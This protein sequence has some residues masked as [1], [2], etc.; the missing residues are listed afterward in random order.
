MID[1]A[2][3]AFSAP[4]AYLPELARQERRQ[5]LKLLRLIAIGL[6][7]FELFG[8]QNSPLLSI[9]GALL[10]TAAALLP[11]Y[12]WCSG[13]ALGL[14]IFPLS[15]LPFVWTHAL[16]LISQHP[17]IVTY[18]P[19]NHLYA[20]LTTTGFL[21]LGTWVW[22][23]FVKSPPPIPPAYRTLSGK[24]GD[25]F[26]LS[27][28]VLGVLFNIAFTGGW[29]QLGGG[30]FALLR[31]GILGLTALATFALSYRAGSYELST[32]QIRLF[33]VLLILNMITSAAGLLL[34][35]AAATFLVAAIAFTVG[36]KKPPVL[37]IV[38][39]LICLTCLHTGK[40]EMRGKY[41]FSGT[42][43]FVQP[44]Q[45]P[46]WYSEW[47]GYSLS[48]FN[49]SSDPQSTTSSS[50][51]QSFLE[52]SSVIHL[53]LLAQDKT[54]TLVPYLNGE[55]YAILPQLLIPRIFNANKI[56]SHEGTYILNI[57]Y[58]LQRREDTNNTTIGWGLLNEAYANFGNFG[59]AGLAIILGIVYGKTTRW[60]IN[61]PLLSA[62]SL[63]SILMI[64]F[65][66][67]TEW[68]AGVHIT[69]L[70]QS[71]VTLMGIVVFLMQSYPSLPQNSYEAE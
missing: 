48:N 69:A 47:V 31:G 23:Q 38:I 30:S 1:K 55:T 29:F 70:F 71:S 16:P 51:Q 64:T 21:L 8:T 28:L 45:Y 32:Q 40:S 68:T 9:I 22:F 24:K 54:P 2:P 61:A 58:G 10:I 62:Q 46:T 59:C 66:F 6:F 25:S 3:L 56:R 18:P 35:G 52:R 4:I 19:I 53:L 67:Q 14:P 42:P 65:A 44:W 7:I 12:L 5:S 11:T 39:T 15:A 36:R 33:W 27:V 43:T 17:K 20:S 57:H 26:F 60:S 41:W 50:N 49:L 63:F 34:V 37:L 13:R